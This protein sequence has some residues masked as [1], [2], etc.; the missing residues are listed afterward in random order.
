MNALVK[1]EI[2]LLLPGWSVAM[3]LAMVQ[4]ITQPYDFYVAMLLFFGLTIICAI[5]GAALY[6]RQAYAARRVRRVATIK[7]AAAINEA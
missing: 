4:G 2:H 5:R 6:C 3:L 7:A 1:K